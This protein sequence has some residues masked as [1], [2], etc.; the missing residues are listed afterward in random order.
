M[1]TLDARAGSQHETEPPRPPVPQPDCIS[2]DPAVGTIMEV[3][4]ISS[5][6][7]YADHLLH[8]KAA[9]SFLQELSCSSKKFETHKAKFCRA[10]YSFAG[11]LTDPYLNQLTGGVG[12]L[13]GPAV[14]LHLILPLTNAFADQV[15]RG[16][17]QHYLVCPGQGTRG[18]HVYNLYGYT[19]GSKNSANAGKTNQ[20]LQA[21]LLEIEA[22]PKGPT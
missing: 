2:W 21:I 20:L 17:A 16:R 5:M 9:V 19:G 7:T 15:Q 1:P 3:K 8:R 12:A 11:T 6:V 18:I 22:L 10:G 4:N 13:A 14:G